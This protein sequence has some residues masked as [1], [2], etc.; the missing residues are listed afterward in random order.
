MSEPL[1]I[2]RPREGVRTLDP[3]LPRAWGIALSGSRILSLMRGPTDLPYGARDE[4]S[5]EGCVLPGFTDAH[6]HFP[7]WALSRR[8]L[9]LGDARSLE[10][11]TTT[12]ARARHSELASSAK[13]IRGRGFRDA[14]WADGKPTRHDLDSVCSDVPVALFSHDSHTLW[15]NT[16]ALDRAAEA[17]LDIPGGVVE[18][19]DAGRPTGVLREEAAWNF[20]ERHVMPSFEETLQAVREALP[21]A[22]AQ[23]IV[24]IHDKDGHRGA[25]EC[26]ATLAAGSELPL[27]VWQSLPVERLAEV[28]T[29]FSGFPDAITDYFTVG[30]IKTYMDGTLGSG[31]ARM[32]GGGGVEITSCAK[33]Q[34]I[35]LEAAAQGLPVAVHAIGDQANRDALDAFEATRSTWGPLELRHR[36]EHA[37]CVDPRDVQRFASLGV[38][39]SVTFPSIASDRDI[40]TERWHDRLAGAFP[41]RS[42]LDVGAVVAG[43]SDAPIEPLDPLLG[44]RSAVLR[45]TDQRPPW[46]PE[47]AIPCVAG[48]R[49]ISSAPAWLE[50]REH[51]RG[52]LRPGKF[53]DL[54]VVDRDPC[55][56]AR[57][58]VEARVLATM[59]G[60]TWT[61]GA[62]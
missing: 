5:I 42:L 2:L 17:S 3:T 22:S 40:V 50:K 33:L 62:P 35:I 30:Y 9:S 48:L 38:A 26:F 29:Q 49:A 6:V 36:I 43:G 55:E 8:E 39:A 18:R 45:T 1:Q 15:V 31:T 54:V 12:I 58:L 34:A 51:V 46:K 24:A 21:I 13:W 11:A 28:A 23:G 60:G 32:I 4:M 56:D 52:S 10:E 25:P 20:Y 7:T 37:Q 44:L 19:D 27:R 47:E 57:A 53:A 61:H 16:V 41:V 14:L 59:V